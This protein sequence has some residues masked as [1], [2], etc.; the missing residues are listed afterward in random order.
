MVLVVDDEI[1]SRQAV[2]LALA[3]ASL[4]SISVDDPQ[5]ALKLLQENRF[6]LIF[7]DVEMPG[8]SGFELCAKLRLLPACKATPVVFVTSLTDFGNRA[9]SALSGGNDLIAKPFLLMEL[10]VKA[11]TCVLKRQITDNR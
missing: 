5:V 9:H 6:S 11:L 10:A 1:I 2:V 7:L 4:A 8:M 3:R